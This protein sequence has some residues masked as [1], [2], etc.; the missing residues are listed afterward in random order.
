MSESKK[1]LKA[2]IEHLNHILEAINE[3]NVNQNTLDNVISTI[4]EYY[5]KYNNS[6][7]SSDETSDENSEKEDTLYDKFI[8]DADIN[9]ELKKFISNTQIY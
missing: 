2:F 1:I 8:K 3:D 5:K 4:K 7:E 9:D 6:E